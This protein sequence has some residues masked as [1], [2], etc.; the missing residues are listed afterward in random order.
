MNAPR[1]APSFGCLGF[2]CVLCLIG[3]SSCELAALRWLNPDWFD[4]VAFWRGR[5]IPPEDVWLAEE[6]PAQAAAPVRAV[7]PA[8]P[9]APLP[10]PLVT[11]QT[12]QTDYQPSRGAVLSTAT[13]GRFEFPPGSIQGAVQVQATPVAWVPGQQFDETRTLFGDCYML[14]IGEREHYQFARPI[15]VTLKCFDT[16]AK[17]ARS[18]AQLAVC[19]QEQDGFR[20]LPSVVNPARGTVTAEVPH[21][22]VITVGG[23]ALL[24]Y[25]LSYRGELVAGSLK[26]EYEKFT[27]EHFRRVYKTAHFSLRWSDD[28][29]YAIPGPEGLPPVRQLITDSLD[30]G[31]PH[32][33]YLM[34]EYLEFSFDHLAL[35][36]MVASDPVVYRNQ[37]YFLPGS[38]FGQTPPSGPILLASSWKDG[39]ALPPD[40]RERL[41]HV[42]AH[43]LIHTIQFR[44]YGGQE[45]TGGWVFDWNP[46]WWIEMNAAY[47]ADLFWEKQ[48][49]RTA[50][51]KNYYM[52]GDDGKL[53]TVPMYT[54]GRDNTKYRYA[55][56][57]NWL[58]TRSKDQGLNV[59]QR[60]KD[61]G[62]ISIKALADA[63]K[64]E[65]GRPLGEVFEEFAQYYY[66]DD[67]VRKTFHPAEM[68][69]GY[70]GCVLLMTSGGDEFSLFGLQ[71][72]TPF[73]EAKVP[74]LKGLSSFSYPVWIDRLP[75][76][77]KGKLVVSFLP[78]GGTLGPLRL[79]A[80]AAN[81]AGDTASLPPW[82]E[83]TMASDASSQDQPAHAMFVAEKL[84]APGGNNLVSVVLTNRT[85][86]ED[87]KE[88]KLRRWLLL[89]PAF[90][91]GE[92]KGKAPSRDWEV[93]W[94]KA[95]LKEFA[96]A[97]KGYKLY[98][99]KPGD[100][101]SAFQFVADIA[102]DKGEQY[103]WTA[104]DLE[105]YVFAVKVEDLLGNL[106]EFSPVDSD[107]PFQGLWEG[108]FRLADGSLVEPLIKAAREYGADRSKQEDADIAKIQDAAQRQQARQAWEKQK[109]EVSK[110]WNTVENWL[111]QFEQIMRLGVPA[112][113]EIRRTEGK[114][115][116][117]CKEFCWIPIKPADAPE[118]E[119][120]RVGQYTLAGQKPFPK[121][122][123]PFVRLHRAS[124]GDAEIRTADN[125][126]LIEDKSDPKNPLRCLIKWSFKRIPSP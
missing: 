86:N 120:K 115:Y 26:Q 49:E 95:E 42:A 52:K 121:A 74:V 113:F 98:R 123:V 105:D 71:N 39:G 44:Y 12:V 40:I 118:L 80:S 89:A 85:L 32:F 27:D 108:E 29:A 35:V 102:R 72:S 88:G 63:V 51:V 9:R 1:R 110:L 21:C 8:A 79:T 112:Q 103:T 101:D 14:R 2:F 3:L 33:I 10:V 22:S 19:V 37:V 23:P 58:D 97:F 65:C 46:L 94:H 56:F 7:P 36:G 67:L 28:P 69:A 15:R 48:G 62:K 73:V 125:E 60:V 24:A 50:I 6:S 4:R 114:Y 126:Y 20:A 109:A 117:R 66:R 38:D 96:E 47:L 124:A 116:S 106:S 84:G 41:R 54:C 45:Y 78:N 81:L 61:G 122:P 119:L 75:A 64:A 43:E 17:D 99:R 92:R 100:P 31:Y 59:C 87:S 5:I 93:T 91:Q 18:A 30:P 107:D 13:G 77:R 25:L 111:R 82:Q 34:G 16:L 104:P 83:V 90:A 55:T 53:P 57:L 70:R 76:E 11:T 68:Y